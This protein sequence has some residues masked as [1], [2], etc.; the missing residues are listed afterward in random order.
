[1]SYKDRP[2]LKPSDHDKKDVVEALTIIL[3]MGD[4]KR[5]TLHAGGHWGILVCSRGCCAL[6]VDGTPRNPSGHARRI[7]REARKCP[8]DDGDV[9]NKT[10]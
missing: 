10:R 5:F 4:G 2:T 1:M 7:L 6:P 8:R 3:A 9:Q